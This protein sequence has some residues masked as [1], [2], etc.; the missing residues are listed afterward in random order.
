VRSCK[1][2]VRPGPESK[3]AGIDAESG[4]PDAVSVLHAGTQGWTDISPAHSGITDHG[5]V[6]LFRCYEPL[7]LADPLASLL[8]LMARL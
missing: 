2:I 1:A 3:D 8:V 4:G 5:K 6:R 7:R